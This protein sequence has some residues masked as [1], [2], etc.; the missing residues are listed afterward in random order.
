LACQSFESKKAKIKNLEN[1]FMNT[2]KDVTELS[3]TENLDL[4]QSYLE[5]R[6]YVRVITRHRVSKHTWFR[7]FLEKT[8]DEFT[9]D[10]HDG[11]EGVWL[12]D[13]KG[14]TFLGVKFWE[15][16]NKLDAFYDYCD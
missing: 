16:F 14:N 12:A 13:F 5:K 4:F 9:L 7:V 2:K 1:T 6:H 11:Y 10:F 3:V 15:V 8:D